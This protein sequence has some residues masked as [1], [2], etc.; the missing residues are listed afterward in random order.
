MEQNKI[1]VITKVLKKLDFIN[2]DR[3]FEFDGGCSF[4]GWI[5]RKDTH[6]DFVILDFVGK[7]IGYA[8]S[9]KGHSKQIGDALN[10]EH[11]ECKRVEYFC[12]IDNCIKL[13]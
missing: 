11:S 5:N 12:D 10:Q 6:E 2:W 7:E 3:Y 13:K 8:T 9:S 4:F 1:D